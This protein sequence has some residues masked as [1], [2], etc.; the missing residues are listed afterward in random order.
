LTRCAETISALSMLGVTV[1]RASSVAT[2]I[3][4]LTGTPNRSSKVKT[5]PRMISA[6][7]L[8]APR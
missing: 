5:T 8:Q 3:E 4:K 2:P 7:M 1:N 6:V